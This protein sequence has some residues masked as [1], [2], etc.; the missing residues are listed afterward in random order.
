MN[1]S[2]ADQRPAE[3]GQLAHVRAFAPLEPEVHVEVA[4]LPDEH[5]GLQFYRVN[6]DHRRLSRREFAATLTLP[7]LLVLFAILGYAQMSTAVGAGAVILLLLGL[8][9]FAMTGRPR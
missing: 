8:V 5:R 4:P 1:G 9:A 3:S 7:A 6:V 2:A